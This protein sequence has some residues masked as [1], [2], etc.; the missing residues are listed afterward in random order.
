MNG[1]HLDGWTWKG[2]SV[3]RDDGGHTRTFHVQSAR[4]FAPT[5]CERKDCTV[6]EPPAPTDHFDHYTVVD[7]P[8]FGV[9]SKWIIARP[10]VRCRCGKLTAQPLPR[11]I[12]KQ[13]G[14]TARCRTYILHQA[15][16]RPFLQVADEI[17]VAESTVWAVFKKIETRRFR[18]AIAALPR[19]R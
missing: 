13:R 16:W 3:N 4:A 15:A 5:R 10:T 6:G 9:R 12:D 1:I 14:M 11:Y 19:D 17:G 7:I 8:A 2:S 18:G